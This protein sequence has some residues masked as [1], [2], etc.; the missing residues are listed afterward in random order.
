MATVCPKGLGPGHPAEQSRLPRLLVDNMRGL[1]AGSEAGEDSGQLD[2][3]LGD[4]THPPPSPKTTRVLALASV[5]LGQKEGP[6]VA[7]QKQEADVRA[8]SQDASF[9]G[10]GP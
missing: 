6:G 2:R 10:D 4:H 5:E 3:A 8:G 7:F 1:W 9:P